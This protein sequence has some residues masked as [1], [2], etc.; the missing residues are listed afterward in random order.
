LVKEI[1]ETLGLQPHPEGGY[2]KETYRSSGVIPQK[3]LPD[4]F[5]GSR[6]YSTCIY[7]LL[8]SGDFS[9]FHKIRQDEIWH[10][11]IGSPIDLYS[12]SEDGHLTRTVVGNDINKD[13]IP[14]FVVP[15]NYW[16]AAT[17]TLKD[18]FSLVGCTVAPGFDFKDFTL[19]SREHL[20][21]LF[22][23]HSEIIKRFTRH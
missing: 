2:F 22:P 7:Y 1:I 23:Q 19:A 5:Q 12:I 16:F 4:S 20:T 10:F 18:G 14:Q 9:A 11:Y 13:Q 15:K 6:H 8:Q 17:V 21:K 3:S